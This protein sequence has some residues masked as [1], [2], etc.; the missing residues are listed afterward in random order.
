LGSPDEYRDRILGLKVGD[1]L[2]Q[3]DILRRL[4]DLQYARNDVNLCRVVD[5]AQIEDE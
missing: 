2:D 4:V 3:R 1:Q 5:R